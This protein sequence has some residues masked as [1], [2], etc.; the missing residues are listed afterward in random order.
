[1]LHNTLL[2]VRKVEFGGTVD[3]P[4]CQ[5]AILTTEISKPQLKLQ[6]GYLKKR[7]V[8]QHTFDGAKGHILQGEKKSRFKVHFGDTK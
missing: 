5:G 8:T 4:S 3:I 6:N 2:T 1:M 7:N